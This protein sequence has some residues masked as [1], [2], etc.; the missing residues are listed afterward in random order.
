M[1]GQLWARQAS[2][3]S[4]HVPFQEI[5]MSLHKYTDGNHANLQQT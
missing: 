2:K 3:E 5:W 1:T 4:S